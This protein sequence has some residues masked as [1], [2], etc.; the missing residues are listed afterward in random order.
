MTVIMLRSGLLLHVLL[1]TATA[2]AA[3]VATN[4]KHFDFVAAASSRRRPAF[5]RLYSD[6]NPPPFGDWG[7]A[8]VAAP[9]AAPMFAAPPAPAAPMYPEPAPVVAPAPAAV[10]TT[11]AVATGG[12]GDPIATLASAQDAVVAKICAGI[13]DLAPK[14]S[15]SWA[16][17]SVSVNGSPATLSAY[18]AP[19]AANVAWLCNVH[20]ANQLSSLTIFNGPLTDVP[21]VLSRCSF[22]DNTL[23]LAIDIR[24]RAY[25]AYELQD[26][27]TGA[28]PGPE[29][30][31]RKAFEY[32]GARNDFF[33][34]FGTDAVK[35]L[36]DSNQFEGAT[37]V[38][39][40]ELELLTGGPLALNVQMPATD[41]N[42]QKVSA[43]R[44]AIA[45]AWLQWNGEPNHEHRPGAPVNTQY[46]YDSKFRQNCYSAVLPHYQQLFGAA[47][48]ATLA[49]AESG[50]L[51]EAYVGG[52]S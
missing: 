29:E 40:T 16:P 28:Y 50:P 1:T 7:A 49:A 36:L 26:P 33:T 37:V 11:P 14:E 6:G 10:A 44:T 2:T 12:G 45:E 32:S 51:D 4:Q 8:P 17:G 20:I 41:A 22:K 5:S 25:G 48:G 34:K 47:D 46:V 9:P 24:P 31:G 27:A 30:L 15:L 42:V 39:P 23:Q 21:H 19:G 52:G 38:P 35:A 18:D 43:V 13:P 3:F